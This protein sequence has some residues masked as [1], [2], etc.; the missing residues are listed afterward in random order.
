M[1]QGK[2]RNQKGCVARPE[3]QGVNKK[4][5]NPSSLFLNPRGSARRLGSW[6]GFSDPPPSQ[7][8]CK[9]DI[10]RVKKEAV[11]FFCL[12]GQNNFL[13]KRTPKKIPWLLAG[14]GGAGGTPPP[15]GPDPPTDRPP[16]G[17]ISH[18]EKKLEPRIDGWGWLRT[19]QK[20]RGTGPTHG[21]LEFVRTVCGVSPSMPPWCTPPPTMLTPGNFSWQRSRW[22]NFWPLFLRNFWTPLLWPRLWYLPL[23]GFLA[24]RGRT[25]GGAWYLSTA[26]M[27]F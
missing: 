26:K 16:W 2:W 12:V 24:K 18:L 13:R 15:G 7:S 14:P 3:S 10:L 8:H 5:Q 11:T 6:L 4:N 25:T 17:G 9:P 27:K 21:E 22:R 23:H 1:L 19:E 20:E